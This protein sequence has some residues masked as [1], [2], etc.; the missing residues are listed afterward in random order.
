MNKHRLLHYLAV[1]IV[2]VMYF[3]GKHFWWCRMLLRNKGNDLLF[4]YFIE[5][6]NNVVISDTRD[7]GTYLYII[8]LSNWAYFVRSNEFVGFSLK[9]NCFRTWFITKTSIPWCFVCLMLSRVIE[10][11]SRRN[12]T[13]NCGPNLKYVGFGVVWWK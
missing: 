11:C 10:V 4:V 13:I 1:L 2:N 8:F 7:T 3:I 5:L 12:F 9:I 6:P